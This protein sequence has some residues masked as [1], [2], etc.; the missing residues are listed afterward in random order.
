MPEL[1]EVETVRAG[2]EP[3][4]VGAQIDNVVLNRP[5]LRFAFPKNFVLDLR[6]QNIISISRR[7]KYLLFALSNERYL[8]AHLGMSGNFRFLTQ[9]EDVKT[10]KHLHVEFSI[11][12]KDGTPLKLIYTDPRRFGFMDIISNLEESRFLKHL[13]AEP[14]GNHFSAHYL[15][16][17]FKNRRT[18]IKSALL[19]QK[20][21]AGLGNIYVCEA[22]WRVGLHPQALAVSL[23][24]KNGA[25]AKKLEMLVSAIIDILQEAIM[26]G[27]STLNDFHN[28]T[29]EKGYFQHSFDVY[30]REREPCTKPG[31]KGEIARISQSG[32]S[33]FFCP[34]CQK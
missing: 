28:T 31:C 16:D 19:D 5:D 24:Q 10:I 29:G 32:R 27:G 12:Q 6:N 33:T 4:I 17:I 23:V 9:D 8:L 30:G 3:L 11:C 15:A 25:P 7:A 34:S 14:L 18:P 26:A 20:N 22:L 1:P 13:G 2:L 21:I